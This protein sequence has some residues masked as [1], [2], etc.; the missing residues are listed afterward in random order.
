MR[1]KI[2]KI[3]SGDEYFVD[4]IEDCIGEMDKSMYREML[5]GIGKGKFDSILMGK[6]IMELE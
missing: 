1:A 5:T 6:T 4:S 2:T 3:D